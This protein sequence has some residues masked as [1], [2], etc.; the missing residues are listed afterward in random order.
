MSCRANAD[1]QGRASIKRFRLAISVRH[2]LRIDDIRF[3]PCWAVH[4][5]YARSRSDVVG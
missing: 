2:L 3:K 1:G 5:E 4:S